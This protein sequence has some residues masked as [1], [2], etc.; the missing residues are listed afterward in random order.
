MAIT[1]I[2]GSAAAI[3]ST[4]SFTPQAWRII[5]TGDTKAISTGMYVITVI[6]FALWTS[7]G[8]G[9]RQW[10]LVASNTIC[11]LMSAF[12]LAMKLLPGR[13][14]ERVRKTLKT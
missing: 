10:P 13:K 7:Y 4:I 14:K 1:D 3:A 9:L 11:F 2:L 8:V 12:I 5:R 6:G